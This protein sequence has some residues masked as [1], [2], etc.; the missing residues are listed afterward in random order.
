MKKKLISGKRITQFVEVG[1]FEILVPDEVEEHEILNYALKNLNNLE[2]ISDVNKKQTLNEFV[3]SN[4]KLETTPKP[5]MAIDNYDYEEFEFIESHVI[6][7]TLNQYIIKENFEMFEHYFLKNINHLKHS[8][9]YL[10]LHNSLNNGLLDFAKL[11]FINSTD[12]LKERQ[13]VK[14]ILNLGVINDNSL[15]RT[16]KQL[17]YDLIDFEGKTLKELYIDKGFADLTHIFN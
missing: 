6:K 5:S 3:I 1:T 2:P 11:L 10:L 9:Y 7:E 12:I 13:I 15:L 8:E 17:N 14:L 16:Y 4:T